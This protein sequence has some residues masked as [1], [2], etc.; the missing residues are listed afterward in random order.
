[1]L[2]DLVKKLTML[3]PER[4]FI[5]PTPNPNAAHTAEVRDLRESMISSSSGAMNRVKKEIA[6]NH[7][8]IDP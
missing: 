3:S 5:R 4:T 2:L 8:L 1:M 6:V 7:E